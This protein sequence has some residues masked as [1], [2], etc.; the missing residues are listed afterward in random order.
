MFL[1]AERGEMRRIIAIILSE[2][3]DGNVLSVVRVRPPIEFSNRGEFAIELI[4]KTAL[5]AMSER[6]GII[7][8]EREKNGI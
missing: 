5:D 7:S 3:E 4:A 2:D 6:W 1:Y 8:Q